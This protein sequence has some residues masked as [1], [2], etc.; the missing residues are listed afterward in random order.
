M[1]RG[2]KRPSSGPARERAASPTIGFLTH[3]FSRDHIS[4]HIW[5]GIT[6]QAREE[7]VNLICFPG[8]APHSRTDFDAQANIIYKL[9]DRRNLDGL[10]LWGSG[11]LGA[12]SA[13]NLKFLVDSLREYPMINI[14]LSLQDIPGILIDNYRGMREACDHLIERHGCRRISFFRGPDGHEEADLRFSAYR[15]SLKDHGLEYDP[16][17][18]IS[19]NFLR[20]DAR[21]SL[22]AFLD[23]RRELPDALVAVNDLTALAVV[24]VLNERHIAIPDQV[25]VVGFDDLD[26]GHYLKMPL[27]TVRQPFYEIGKMAVR[28]LLARMQGEDIPLISTVP[29]RLIVRQSCGCLNPLVTQ[30]AVELPALPPEKPVRPA[31]A[32]D[33]LASALTHDAA[34]FIGQD[35]TRALTIE[36]I[37]R[38]AADEIIGGSGS[39]IDA[40]NR[41]LSQSNWQDDID[42]FHTILS[43]LRRSFLPL[44]SG[45]TNKLI[46]AENLWHQSRVLVCDFARRLAILA[47][48]AKSRHNEI[49]QNV[50]RILVTSFDI[51]EFFN[52]L[53]EALA[54]LELTC[55]FLSLYE[56][57]QSHAFSRLRLA[58]VDGRRLDIDRDGIRFPSVEL[59]PPGFLPQN[60]RTSF[61]IQPLYFEKEQLGFIILEEGPELGI[62]NE[63]LRA[64]LSAAVQGAL[65]FQERGRLLTALEQRAR[66]LQESTDDLARANAE[67]EQFAV[68]TS[69]DLQEPL[70]KISLF[71]DRLKETGGDRDEGRRRDYLDRMQAACL[72]MKALIRDLLTYSR[73]SSQVAHFTDVDVADAVRQALLDL[74]NAVDRS[75][76]EISVEELP[77]LLA[78]EHHVRLLF[79]HLLGNALKFQPGGRIPRIRVFSRTLSRNGRTHY[80]ITVEDNGIGIDPKYY[81]KIF[82]VF[83]RLHGAREFEGT[84]MGL[85][86]CKK[87]VDRHKGSIRIESEPGKGARFSVTL[88]ASRGTAVSSRTT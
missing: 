83:Q 43:G 41:E 87:I 24:D 17:L 14:G 37:S 82:G 49:L 35:A 36:R 9:I 58:I 69:H 27:T 46:H 71:A 21:V 6:D 20:N 34:S 31:A 2:K 30:S 1:M 73:L 62:V 3:Y 80:E 25:K 26:E 45:E 32:A 18:I 40:F 33:L 88:P 53:A 38:A 72:R 8:N 67:L 75:R 56:D 79:Y 65:L 52:S 13:E 84:G 39:Y 77:T 15:D 47:G 23:E 42:F 12:T 29:S 48:Y 50:N 76:A 74:G 57:R 60:R 54:Q 59:T 4:L 7:N 64:Q 81:E 55:C 5:M 68:I 28:S 63:I 86:V 16:R 10:L 19:G 44:V 11:M 78:E 66:Q 61:V 22:R 70:R 51:D 85:A